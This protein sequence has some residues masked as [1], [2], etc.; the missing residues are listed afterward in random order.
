MAVRTGADYVRALRDGREVWH[1][2]RRIE[3]VTAHSGFTGTIKTLADLYDKQHTSEYREVM[4]LEHEGER[5]SCSYLAPKNAEQLAQKRRNIEF[6]AQ[7]TFGQMGRYPDFCA[8][9]VV[10]LFD[11]AHVEPRRST[12]AVQGDH[13]AFDVFDRERLPGFEQ[14]APH[15]VPTATARS[16]A[17]FA[18]D[19]SHANAASD[20][21]IN[22]RAD[23]TAARVQLAC[24]QRCHLRSAGRAEIGHF[25]VQPLVV[26]KTLLQRY[27]YA[28]IGVDHQEPDLDFLLSLRDGAREQAKAEPGEDKQRQNR[29]L[30]HAATYNM[31]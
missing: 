21:V 16:D 17:R 12:D 29:F 4:T 7:Q 27:E 28:G 19:H 9:L 30:S 23:T 18:G 20:R 5:L 3:D 13:F 14:A 26:K 22:S 10:G 6:W 15:H 25:D 11:W 31:G 1:A 8:Q 24:G 2:G